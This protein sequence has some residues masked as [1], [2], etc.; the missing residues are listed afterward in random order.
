MSWCRKCDLCS[1]K[2]SKGNFIFN[3]VKLSSTSVPFNAV[4][5]CTL[6]F[7]VNIF[8]EHL[9]FSGLLRMFS[10]MEMYISAVSKIVC[11]MGR[12]STLGL[13]EQLMTVIGK[14]EK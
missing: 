9:F 6:C 5:T 10:Q 1:W 14:M 4:I 2:I 7:L 12:E 3:Q 8:E 11:Y 13:M